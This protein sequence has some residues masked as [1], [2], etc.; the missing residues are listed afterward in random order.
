MLKELNKHNCMTMEETKMKEEPG[1]NSLRRS[2]TMDDRFLSKKASPSSM[3]SSSYRPSEAVEPFTPNNLENISSK[4]NLP[5]IM[6]MPQLELCS[7]DTQAEAEHTP[8][9]HWS[10]NGGISISSS[11]IVNTQVDE[12][13]ITAAKLALSRVVSTSSS[14]HSDIPSAMATAVANVSSLPQQQNEIM[15]RN[16]R[17]I[18]Q[19]MNKKRRMS[20]GIKKAMTTKTTHQ[21]TFRS[22][23]TPAKCNNRK[24]KHTIV[25]PPVYDDVNSVVDIASDSDDYNAVKKTKFLYYK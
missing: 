3:F 5:R 7:M 21:D 13:D 6:S 9:R 20:I 11:V 15:T 25:S 4:S 22:P 10:Y 16:R 18:D 8:Y 17:R 23:A 14:S 1:N 19:S 12:K 2:I 24:K